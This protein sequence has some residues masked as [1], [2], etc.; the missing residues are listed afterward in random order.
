MIH[1]DLVAAVDG[2]GRWGE[3]N[4]RY[5]S[6]SK[7]MNGLLEAHRQQDVELWIQRMDRPDTQRIPGPYGPLY[8]VG[9][10]GRHRIH[11]YKVL[12]VTSFPAK[13]HPVESEV[14]PGSTIYV[15]PPVPY[16]RPRVPQAKPLAYTG[17][18]DISQ[19][20]DAGIL[21]PDPKENQYKVLR[22]VPA[23]WVMW[24]PSAASRYAVRYRRSYPQ[25]GCDN[26]AEAALLDP[27]TWV[28]YL[29]RTTTARPIAVSQPRH[30]AQWWRRATSRSQ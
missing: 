29:K 30:R 22:P 7:I 16:T 21:E 20:V 14:V 27:R 3:V 25:F 6:Y 1:T 8:E 15:M 18:F 10:D 13:V 17:D 23:Y 28:A 19:L 24:G 11:V 26:E 2:P 12:G 4:N 9:I 5:E